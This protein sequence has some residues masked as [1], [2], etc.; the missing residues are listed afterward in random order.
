MKRISQRSAALAVTLSLVLT[1]ASVAMS[2]PKHDR[3]SKRITISGKVLHV[4]QKARTLLVDDYWS[5]K[6]YLV[7]VP[8]GETYHITFG[9]Y[10]NVA[11]PELWQ[12]RKNDR[13]R[14]R[15]TRNT[16]H[17]AQIDGR[18]AVVMTAAR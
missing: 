5:D 8:K 15:C 11:A 18:Q 4:D 3:A 2:A 14:I 16:E 17:L 1:L 10:M 13:V 12:T 9:M 6:L 7:R